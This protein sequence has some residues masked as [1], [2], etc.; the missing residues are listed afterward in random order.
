MGATQAERRL[1]A[2][3]LAPL[4]E[5]TRKVLETFR[6]EPCLNTPCPYPLLCADLVK[7]AVNAAL[8]VADP[9]R[10][11]PERLGTGALRGLEIF[12]GCGISQPKL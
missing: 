9:A 2:N 6:P 4:R 11:S 12:V 10:R 5:F 7:A 3:K 1:A 8:E